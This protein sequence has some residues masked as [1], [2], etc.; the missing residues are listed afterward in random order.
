MNK[1]LLA[2]EQI[3]AAARGIEIH[4]ERMRAV[5]SVAT[6]A[7]EALRGFRRAMDHSYRV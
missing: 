4:A 5:V 7:R 6:R 3:R 1:P 2:P